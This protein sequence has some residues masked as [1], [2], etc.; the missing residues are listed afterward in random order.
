MQIVPGNTGIEIAKR[1]SNVVS[2]PILIPEYKTFSDGE[3]HLRIIGD[4]EEEVLIVQ[5][6][7]SPQDTNLFQLLNLVRTLK[8][9]GANQVIAYVPYLSYA[10]SDRE[11][12]KGEAISAQTVIHLLE[13]VGV[14]RLIT[15]DVHNDEIFK[16]AEKMECTNIFPRISMR[17]YLKKMLLDFNN[18]Q[19]VAP[20]GGAYHRAKLLA[21]ELNVPFTALEKTRDVKSG[22]VN[23]NVGKAKIMRKEVIL[24]D[25]I[26][27]TGSSL[28]R[29]ASLLSLFDVEKIHILVT[30]AMGTSAVDR[31]N[32]I[33][34]GIIAS[35]FSI[36]SPISKIS[37]IEDLLEVLK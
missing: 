22:E 32:E 36:P 21:E 37:V 28:L 7:S 18:V 15:L 14:D 2:W 12:L 34:Q 35:T 29:A 33:G 17:R 3:T 11:V 25:D 10:R 23:V 8:R 4:V 24:I 19:V 5:S 6:L 26:I 16:F 13:N 9:L 30:H 31:L 1:I 20:D 27:S